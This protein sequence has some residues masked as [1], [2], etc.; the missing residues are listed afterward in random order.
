M[1]RL[2]GVVENQQKLRRVEDQNDNSLF[3]PRKGPVYLSG[4]IDKPRSD[5]DATRTAAPFEIRGLRLL[6]SDSSSDSCSDSYSDSCSRL[7]LR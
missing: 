6:S 7:T 4:E 1:H 5:L 2:P 3:V